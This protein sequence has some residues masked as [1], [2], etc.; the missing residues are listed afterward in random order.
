MNTSFY[1]ASVGASTQQDKMNVIANNIANVNTTGYKS[2]SVAFQ[3][4]MY[5]NMRAADPEFAEQMYAGTGTKVSHTNTNLSG[6]GTLASTDENNFAIMDP[7]G[8]F[9]LRDPITNEIS[10]TRD[11][12]FYLS[13][14]ADGFYLT[15]NGGKLVLDQDEVPI[16]ADE[17]GKLDTKPGVF[18]FINT[19]G[20]ESIGNNELVPVAKNGEPFLILD[21]NVMSG[22]IE[23]S[24]VDLA[25]EIANTIEAQRAYSLNLKMMM[26]SDE[27]QQTINRLRG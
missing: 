27:V 19:D 3:D 26:T 23:M 24:N 16:I 11:G 25:T 8:F 5:Y 20:M 17:E 21:A 12:V 2:K 18:D 7:E 10:Y 4:L 22:R 14:R 15:T 1:T 9:M 13:D 6:A